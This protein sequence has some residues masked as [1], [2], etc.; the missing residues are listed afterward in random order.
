MSN[1]SIEI[2]V[3]AWTNAADYWGLFFDMNEKVYKT[4]PTKG[5]KFPYPH[6]DVTLTK[7]A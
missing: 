1:S 6:M 5:L 3:R 4:F 2:V 7:E